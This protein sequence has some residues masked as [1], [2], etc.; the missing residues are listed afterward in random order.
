M[1][2]IKHGIS[3]VFFKKS[4][5]SKF[6]KKDSSEISKDT[7]S[8]NPLL[9]ISLRKYLE[10]IFWEEKEVGVPFK[11]LWSITLK[12]FNPSSSH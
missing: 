7:L 9:H 3:W 8:Y 12:K 4:C 10:F 1:F 2:L 6:M 5:V 11:S